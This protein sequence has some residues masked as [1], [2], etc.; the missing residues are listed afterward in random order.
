MFVGGCLEGGG[1][2]CVDGLLCMYGRLV[3]EVEQRTSCRESAR[4]A[5][6]SEPDEVYGILQISSEVHT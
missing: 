4:V 3:V 1:G 5:T 6:T 2:C